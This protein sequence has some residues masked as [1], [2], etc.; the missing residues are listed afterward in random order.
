MKEQQ[1][2][3]I[4]SKDSFNNRS[5]MATQDKHTHTHAA[6]SD[7]LGKEVFKHNKMSFI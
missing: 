5:D 4:K 3:C 1:L 2:V 7:R 6:E